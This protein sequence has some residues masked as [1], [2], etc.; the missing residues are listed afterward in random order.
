VVPKT[1]S[2]FWLTKLNGNVDRDARNTNALQ[3][4]GW[5]VLTIW[6]CE[7]ENE[8]LLSQKLIAALRKSQNA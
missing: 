7:V 5:K 8:P 2:Q 4:L 3:H 6:E 1:R